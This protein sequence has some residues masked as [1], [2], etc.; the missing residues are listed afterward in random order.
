MITTAA[1][2]RTPRPP[3]YDERLALLREAACRCDDNASEKRAAGDHIGAA[4]SDRDA[5]D[6]WAH[7]RAVRFSGVPLDQTRL[8]FARA[9]V[10]D[11]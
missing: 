1:P 4:Q 5:N 6:L 9:V 3:V 2:I 7:A 8:R 11:H 10:A